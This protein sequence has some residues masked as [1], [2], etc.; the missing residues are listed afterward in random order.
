[1]LIKIF[2]KVKKKLINQFHYLEVFEAIQ[3]AT[4]INPI[5]YGNMPIKVS[6]TECE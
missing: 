3:L 6:L 2:N 4:T 5:I 1:M